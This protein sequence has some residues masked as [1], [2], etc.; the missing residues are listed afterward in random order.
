MVAGSI[1]VLPFYK[2]I[3]KFKKYTAGLVLKK[4]EVKIIKKKNINIKSSKIIKIKNEL[5][6]ILRKKS[7]NLIKIILK[8]K[9]INEIFFWKEKKKKIVPKKI[10]IKNNL[11]KL[12]INVENIIKEK[13]TKKKMS[14]DILFENNNIIF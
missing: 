13:K 5:F 10:F 14:D 7:E 6:L 12:E 8:R 3:I 9:E 4:D 2:K 1:P 11:V